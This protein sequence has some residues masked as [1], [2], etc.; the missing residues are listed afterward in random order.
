MHTALMLGLSFTDP[1][2]IVLIG[3][4]GLFLLIVGIVALTWGKYWLQATASR[5]DV[6]FPSLVGMGFRQ[7]NARTIVDAK[8]MA[9]QALSLIHI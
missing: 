1:L 3:G 8:V 9:A 4:V 6:S 5:A 7:V 2:G